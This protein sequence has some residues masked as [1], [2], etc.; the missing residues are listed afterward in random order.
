MTELCFCGNAP[1]LSIAGFLHLQ[2]IKERCKPRLPFAQCHACWVG[3]AEPNPTPAHP[4]DIG[5][6]EM[7]SPSRPRRPCK[8]RQ[9]GGDLNHGGVARAGAC[10][11]EPRKLTC[12]FRGLLGHSLRDSTPRFGCLR[13]GQDHLILWMDEILH[14]FETMGK[15]LRLFV[16]TGES[17]ETRFLRWCLGGFRNHPQFLT[18]CKYAGVSNLGDPGTPKMVGFPVSL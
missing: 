10:I 2:R 13:S 9:T 8:N 16:F 5:S 1:V 14:H 7:G 18:R 11:P 6:C 3:K 17:S 12:W 15:P 4:P